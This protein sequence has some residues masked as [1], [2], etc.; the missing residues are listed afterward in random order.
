DN[1]TFSGNTFVASGTS[2]GGGLQLENSTGL[3]SGAVQVEPDGWLWVGAEG[4]V[5][6][7][8]S[9]T[10]GNGT[11]GEAW[12]TSDANATWSGHITIDD[13]WAYIAANTSTEFDLTGNISGT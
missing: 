8:N 13:T 9:L 10:L 11:G 2:S 1:S 4:P 12:L 6:V 7:A 3:G 5:D